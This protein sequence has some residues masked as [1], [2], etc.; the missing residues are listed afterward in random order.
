MVLIYAA[1]TLSPQTILDEKVKD[2]FGIKI[3]ASKCKF[4]LLDQEISAT[5]DP[6]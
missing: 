2:R 5:L 4:V 3:D 1:S 6:S